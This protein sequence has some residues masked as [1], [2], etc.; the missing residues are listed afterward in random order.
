M[1][2]LRQLPVNSLTFDNLIQRL[3]LDVRNT[4]DRQ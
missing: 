2:N 3:T 1:I 4:E